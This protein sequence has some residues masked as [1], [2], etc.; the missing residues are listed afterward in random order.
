MPEPTLASTAPCEI[1]SADPAVRSHPP[2][3]QANQG[4][5]GVLGP[6]PRRQ[7]ALLFTYRGARWDPSLP[8]FF[9]EMVKNS[10]PCPQMLLD[11]P[12][13]MIASHGGGSD[14][15]PVTQLACLWV[16]TPRPAYLFHSLASRGP[17]DLDPRG[18]QCRPPLPGPRE[19][20]GPPCRTLPA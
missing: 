1:S 7:Q 13:V 12:S 11:Q 10:G 17:R 4:P 9:L 2:T 8:A 14:H 16:T 20:P 19:P 15:L 6:S 3:E 18:G 5:C